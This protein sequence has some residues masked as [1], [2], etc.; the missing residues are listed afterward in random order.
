MIPI[1]RTIKK[2]DDINKTSNTY[3]ELF[4]NTYQS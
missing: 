3:L 1:N 4:K 2:V